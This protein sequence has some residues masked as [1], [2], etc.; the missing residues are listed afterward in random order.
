MYQPTTESIELYAFVTIFPFLVCFSSVDGGLLC[1][2]HV[3][4]EGYR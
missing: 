4:P 1:G 2:E 3:T